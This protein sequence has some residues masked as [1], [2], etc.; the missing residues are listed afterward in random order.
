MEFA[1]KNYQAILT[2]EELLQLLEINKKLL[3]KLTNK[4][5]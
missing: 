5:E 1:H 2:E 4:S 3:E